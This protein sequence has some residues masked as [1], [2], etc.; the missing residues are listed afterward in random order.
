VVL[1][2]PA[3]ASFGRFVDYRDRG[4]QFKAAALR[5]IAQHGAPEESIC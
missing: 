1:L 4:A 2:S 5:L 3:S